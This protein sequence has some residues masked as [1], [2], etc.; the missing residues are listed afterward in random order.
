MKKTIV[1]FLLFFTSIIVAEALP[2]RDPTR[3]PGYVDLVQITA[4]DP[5]K[6]EDLLP[7]LSS[8]MFSHSRRIA[9]L[10]DHFVNEGDMVGNYVVVSIKK[11][12]VVLSSGSNTFTLHL[13]QDV[14]RTM[15]NHQ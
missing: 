11:D 4:A 7:V 2:L 14:S 10:N 12:Y 6:K 15:D 1:T 13:I 5:I 3:P 8:I 9:V